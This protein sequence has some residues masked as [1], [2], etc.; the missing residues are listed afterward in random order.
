MQQSLENAISRL[1]K[2]YQLKALE[3]EN[4]KQE[5]D[6]RRIAMALANFKNA[7]E[8][9]SYDIEKIK[10]F[11][12][13]SSSELDIESVILACVIVEM[14]NSNIKT[15]RRYQEASALLAKIKSEA[16]SY[17]IAKDDLFFKQTECE[18]LLK[19]MESLFYV[20]TNRVIV[21]AESL[22]IYIRVLEEE[23]FQEDKYAVLVVVAALVIRNSQLLAHYDKVDCVN[24]LRKSKLNALDEIQEDKRIDYVIFLKSH[25]QRY[26]N[27]AKEMESSL[28]LSTIATQVEAKK[29]SLEEARSMLNFDDYLYEYF[30]WT[31]MYKLVEYLN[32]ATNEE[33][34]NNIFDQLF[35]TKIV[36]EEILKNNQLIGVDYFKNKKTLLFLTEEIGLD[37]LN[38]KDLTL[39][40]IE[41]IR[42]LKN[43]TIIDE[44]SVSLLNNELS[45]LTGDK[46]FI[47]YKELLN[48]HIIILMFG[49][50]R[51]IN[52][53][54]EPQILEA[55]SN[56]SYFKTIDK[57][58]FEGG[59]SYQKLLK[60]SNLIENQIFK[61]ER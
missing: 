10:L 32:R 50:L 58:I 43:G 54:L 37:I 34:I 16:S 33:G 48:N 22:D 2:I 31:L 24:T 53:K 35:Q 42:R 44:N 12:N 6:V 13:N 4:I 52:D 45:L 11:L 25:E 29:I 28:Q 18:N 59:A 60:E 8:L 15:S 21:D 23:I 17:L 30:L 61:L 7:D 46:D 55:F 1:Q 5:L 47:L 27:I 36:Y 14:A 40:T 38:F 39:E 49:K 20:L 57:I 19:N 26:R 56:S 51:D 9:S 41:L 3:L